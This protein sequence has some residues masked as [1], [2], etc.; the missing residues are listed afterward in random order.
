MKWHV[1]FIFLI[2]CK[3]CLCP[4]ESWAAVESKG[5]FLSGG[6]N[7]SVGGVL[8]HGSLQAFG[9]T[10]AVD[11]A[12]WQATIRNPPYFG[13]LSGVFGGSHN[14]EVAV[15]RTALDTQLIPFDPDGDPMVLDVTVQMGQL[16]EGGQVVTAWSWG[17]NRNG[18]WRASDLASRL[19][20]VLS[21]PEQ[22]AAMSA[23][24]SLLGPL[25]TV[26]VF[27]F[28]P[29]AVLPVTLVQIL[30][31]DSLGAQFVSVVATSQQNGSV[32]LVGNEI[33]YEPPNGFEGQD[34]IQYT[35]EDG[36]SRQATGSIV[37][38]IGNEVPRIVARHLFYNDSKWDAAT[39][40]AGT[41]DDTGVASDKT[42]LLPNQTAVIAN[43]STF[44]K[45]INGIMIDIEGL[46]GSVSHDDFEFRVGNNNTP[47]T[48]GVGPD[49]SIIATR[50]GGGDSGSDRVTLV[51]SNQVILKTWLAV[52]VKATAI[53]GLASSDIF[54]FGNAV[55]KTLGDSSFLVGAQ[56]ELR[57]RANQ[58]GILNPAPID[59]AHDVNRDGLVN[60]QDQLITRGNGTSVLTGLAVITPDDF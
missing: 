58:R 48:W 43:V 44:S 6:A 2:G 55:G 17:E 22:S 20:V 3:V 12:G 42:A 41:D 29:G 26:D 45:G 54:Y 8:S 23:D 60:A 30:T 32:Q 5:A 25:A 16:L 50:L 59:D 53:T 19:Q 24:M 52:K 7:Q 28:S 57:I 33:R 38:E 21:D 15:T 51:W 49:P 1:T 14:S 18:V 13:N 11:S 36:D 34:T 31:N 9:A 40:G 10:S 37:I 56:D 39:P 27:R 4:I 35:I 46:A 47:S